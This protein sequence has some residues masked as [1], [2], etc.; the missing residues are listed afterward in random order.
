MYTRL[1]LPSTDIR[2]PPL[3]LLPPSP[4]NSNFA[5]DPRRVSGRR[6]PRRHARRRGEARL[7]RPRVSQFEIG[8]FGVELACRPNQHPSALA[9]PLLVNSTKR[10]RT[11]FFPS[12]L[13]LSRL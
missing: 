13:R 2:D 7:V 11:S 12:P 4:L 8:L 1:P 5:I 3:L 6:S 9:Y 10:E